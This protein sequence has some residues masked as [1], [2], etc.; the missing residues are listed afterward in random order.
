MAP[1]PS[2]GVVASLASCPSTRSESHELTSLGQ[3]PNAIRSDITSQRDRDNAG[4][5][6]M[7]EGLIGSQTLGG[8]SGVWSLKAQVIDG[9]AEVAPYFIFCSSRGTVLS[10]SVLATKRRC[11]SSYSIFFG[12]GGWGWGGWGWGGQG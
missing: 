9:L 2:G 7:D 5:V 8:S 4:R 12:G 10:C 11:Q 1:A 6:L 3:T